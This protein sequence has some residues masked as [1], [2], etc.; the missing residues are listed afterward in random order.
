MKSAKRSQRGFSLAVVLVMAGVCM[1]L[2]TGMFAVVMPGLNQAG[3]FRTQTELRHAAEAGLDWAVAQYNLDGGVSAGI[4]NPTYNTSGQGWIDVPQNVIDPT[5]TNSFVPKVQLQVSNMQPPQS[6]PIYMSALAYLG[7]NTKQQ[8]NGITTNYW[9]VVTVKA[10]PVNGTVS[11]SLQVIMQPYLPPPFNFKAITA[12]R[13]SFAGSNFT[14]NAY[15]SN[16]NTNPTSYSLGGDIDVNTT[17]DLGNSTVNGSVISRAQPAGNMV[18]SY[19]MG[20]NNAQVKGFVK[21]NGL[22]DAAVIPHISGQYIDTN[23]NTQ[24]ASPAFYLSQDL[25]QFQ[26]PVVPQHPVG[27]MHLNPLN[28][29]TS[30]GA[31]GQTS[32]YYI[33][34]GGSE[35]ALSGQS[36]ITVNGPTRIYLEGDT[37][38][39]PS[40]VSFSGKSAVSNV[41]QR[42]ADLMLFYGGNGT[43]D[44]SGLGTFCGIIV[45]PNATVKM[46][47]NAQ[48]YGA[49]VG[50]IVGLNGGGN[51]GAVHYDQALDGVN[52]FPSV[53]SYQVISWR[54]L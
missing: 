35:I 46:H 43:I 20:K 49:I 11:K 24:T 44:I 53:A 21:S 8:L 13:V 22:I 19:V 7:P 29:N 38:N 32:N 14:T 25:P 39:T 6:S 41:S 4:D 45:A 42:P 31:A 40:V 18:S 52:P 17:I 10:S 16:I 2:V 27:S 15:N 48:I 34:A 12:S 47:G 26:M 5:G 36:T 30:L 33:D 3:M 50:N 51:S 1:F 9:R 37:S 28:S 23:G 54:E